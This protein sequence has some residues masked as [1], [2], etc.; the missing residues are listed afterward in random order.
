MK[1]DRPPP[2]RIKRQ[3]RKTQIQRPAAMVAQTHALQCRQPLII[4]TLSPEVIQANAHDFMQLVQKLTGQGSD[5]SPLAKRL[6]HS[7]HGRNSSEDLHLS[8]T[9]YNIGV[10]SFAIGKDQQINTAESGLDRSLFPLNSGL[11]TSL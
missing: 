2:L 9:L 7:S 6:C 3:E 10:S 8:P 1:R 11:P 4:Q 5:V